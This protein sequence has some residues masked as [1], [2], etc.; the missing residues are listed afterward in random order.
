MTKKE[1]AVWM[2]TFLAIGYAIGYAFSI[3]LLPKGVPDSAGWLAGGFLWL[4]FNLIFSPENISWK[5]FAFILGEIVG[6]LVGVDNGSLETSTLVM[7][8]FIAT[9]ISIY[10]TLLKKPFASFLRKHHFG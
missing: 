8:I 5:S 6:L 1:N 4:F 3:S 7:I 10:V 2:V 9:I